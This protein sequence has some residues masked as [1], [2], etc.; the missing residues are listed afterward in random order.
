MLPAMNPT[1]RQVNGAKMSPSAM[2]VP[3]SFTKQ[4]PRIPLPK[5]VL[6]KPVSSMTA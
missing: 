5:S 6:L 1:V 3:R 4:A 2:T